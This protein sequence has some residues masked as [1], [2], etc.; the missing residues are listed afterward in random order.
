MI[1]LLNIQS[2]FRF[3]AQ[4]YLLESCLFPEPEFRSLVSVSRFFV[5]SVFSSV[6]GCWH[7][8]RVQ[9]PAPVLMIRLRDAKWG[10]S[11]PRPPLQASAACVSYGPLL[12]SD[13]NFDH[14]VKIVPVRSTHCKNY[15]FFS[16]L[17][18]MNVLKGNAWRLPFSPANSCPVVLAFTDVSS[19]NQTSLRCLQNGADS[20]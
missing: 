4:C 10:M 1:P 18:L 11:P 7:F 13:A 17:K 19:P 9:L 3:W 2:E 6:R 20:S 16:P 15:F 8:R 5:T 12:T 14:L